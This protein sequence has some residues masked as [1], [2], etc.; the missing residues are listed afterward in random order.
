[1]NKHDWNFIKNMSPL[2]ITAFLMFLMMV[3]FETKADDHA[4]TEH[5]ILITD[6]DLK[7][8]SIRTSSIRNY[9]II[10]RTTVRVTTNRKEQYDLKL[11]YCFDIDF[12]HSLA[13]VSWGGF[14][15]L[16]RGDKVIPFSFGRQSKNHCTI[17]SITAV[18]KEKEDVEEN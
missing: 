2:L 3:A 7:V 11:Y 1:M 15:S 18:L 9:E 4:Y 10:D 6:E 17:K 12:A 5:G 13:F 14:T 8:N 16:S